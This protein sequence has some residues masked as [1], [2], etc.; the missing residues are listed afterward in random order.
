MSDD[1]V[2]VR[3]GVANVA[4]IEAAFRRLG[5]SVEATDDAERVARATAVVLPG[6]GAFGAGVERLQ[7]GGLGDA[8]AARIA[9]ERPTLAVC[10]GL[11]LLGRASD[12]AAGAT[13]LGVLPAT[14]KRLDGAPRL[15]HFGWN[16][17]E[18][19]PGSTLLAPGDAY[20]AHTFCFRDADAD[21]L[22]ADGWRV[23]TTVEG[24]PFVCAVER[25]SVL[26]CQFHPELSGAYGRDLLARWLKSAR[27][28][29]PVEVA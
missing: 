21:A 25:G 26:A 2:M 19:D 24:E 15:P 7:V 13:G 18:P 3:T 4:S 6:V 20:F 22:R 29:R 14:A 10:L 9:A 1:L 12:E 5:L 23:A 11:Q 8:L 16:R 27:L 28:E 17:V